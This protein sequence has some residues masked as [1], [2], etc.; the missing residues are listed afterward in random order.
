MMLDSA[1]I[2][3]A[4][5]KA[6]AR[7]TGSVERADAL[8]L[9]RRD[10]ASARSARWRRRWRLPCGSPRSAAA[11]RA[12]GGES[13]ARLEVV[14]VV[15]REALAALGEERARRVAPAISP[16]ADDPRPGDLER[17][18]LHVDL[19][20]ATRSGASGSG[21]SPAA[22]ARNGTI[23]SPSSRHIFP[24]CSRT[25]ARRGS[26]RRPSTGAQRVPGAP[27]RRRRC[28]TGS[29]GAGSRT[30]PRRGR[31][32]TCRTHSMSGEVGR[33]SPAGRRPG[34]LGAVALGDLRRSR[35]L[36]VETT[37]GVEQ[38][39]LLRAAAIE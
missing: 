18:V 5:A 25:G 23:R 22:W 29:S 34:H 12:L 32:S 39:A 35:S 7:V 37:H 4:S 24:G 11:A 27:D 13:R 20:A 21:R 16:S 8:E 2:R 30:A 28:G 9:G 14:G 31:S 17:R 19:A 26:S 33:R 1:L 10:V 6:A 38:P 15:D 3:Y 36:S